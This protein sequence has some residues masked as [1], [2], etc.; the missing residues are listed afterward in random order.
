MLHLN[1]VLAGDSGDSLKNYFTF[2]YHSKHDLQFMDFKGFNYP[3]GEHSG[4][5]DCQLLVSFLLH[6]LPFTHDYLAGILN[7]LIFISLIITPLILYNI[8]SILGVQ[9]W[10]AFFTALAIAVLSSQYYK[11]YAGH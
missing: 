11:I 4:Y 5:T 6:Y 3:F 9:R 10:P 1:S 8:L 7:A 2:A